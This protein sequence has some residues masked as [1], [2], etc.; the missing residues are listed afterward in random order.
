MYANDIE[1]FDLHWLTPQGKED[2]RSQQHETDPHLKKAL[3]PK[4]LDKDISTGGIKAQVLVFDD[5]GEQPIFELWENRSWSRA[6]KHGAEPPFSSP[7]L[8]YVNVDFRAS[9]LRNSRSTRRTIWPEFTLHFIA[10]KSI[11]HC[12]VELCPKIGLGERAVQHVNKERIAALP[13]QR[14]SSEHTFERWNMNMNMNMNTVR[15]PSPLK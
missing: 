1:F 5:S 15:E 6:H 10:G 7:L 12:C 14:R 8:L 11:V 13:N 2:E 4:T 9:L 3:V